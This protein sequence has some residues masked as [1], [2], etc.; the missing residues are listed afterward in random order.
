MKTYVVTREDGTTDRITADGYHVNGP[1]LI[2]F[3]EKQQIATV[4]NP[5]GGIVGQ[6]F[7]IY[8]KWISVE[9]AKI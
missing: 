2:F 4:Q 1:Q 9:D 3:R 5:K 7:K 8:N 6:P